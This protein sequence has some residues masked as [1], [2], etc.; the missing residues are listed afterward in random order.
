M[1]SAFSQEETAFSRQRSCWSRMVPGNLSAAEV[2]VE[3][4][5]GTGSELH[6]VRAVSTVVE[7]PYPRFLREGAE[8]CPAGAEEDRRID[9]FG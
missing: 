5:S 9:A 4:A 7:L 8:R 6:V 1:H 3:L 2:A